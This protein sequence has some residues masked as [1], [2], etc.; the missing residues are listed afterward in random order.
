MENKKLLKFLLKDLGELDEL[1]TEKNNNSFDDLEMEFLYTRIKG[2]KKLVQILFEREDNPRNKIENEP[3]TEVVEK[4]IEKVEVQKVVEEKPIEAEIEKEPVIDKVSEVVVE[5]EVQQEDKK[6]AQA[7]EIK[8]EIQEEIEVAP[9]VVHEEEVGLEEE[10][11]A[12]EANQR[13][14]DSFSKEKSVNDLI[15]TDNTK[16]EHKL[17]NRPI[18]SIQTAIGINDRFQYIR[19]LFDGNADSFTKTV[20]EIDAMKDIKEAVGY[21][22][23]NFKWKKNETSLKFVNLVKRRFSN[24]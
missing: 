21:L 24:E 18:S 22:Q 6:E 9:E 5:K 8:E 13:L 23:Q 17:S 3:K 12:D 16:L 14:G 4:V 7:E 10:K 15:G 1:F 2:A 11:V 20:S 19:E